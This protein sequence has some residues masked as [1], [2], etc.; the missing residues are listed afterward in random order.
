MQ[1]HRHHWTATGFIEVMCVGLRVYPLEGK[2]AQIMGLY[3]S[4]IIISM[5]FGPDTLMFGDLDA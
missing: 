5:V 3:V 4:H 1:Q 2:I